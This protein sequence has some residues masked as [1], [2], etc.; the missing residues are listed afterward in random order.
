MRL[1]L[2]FRGG[3]YIIRN[4]H[5]VSP[6]G[7][8]GADFILSL[9]FLPISCVSLLLRIHR[10]SFRG[11]WTQ[12]PPIAALWVYMEWV[13]CH[14]CL[15]N[16]LQP[17]MNQRLS[18]PRGHTSCKHNCFRTACSSSVGVCKQPSQQIYAAPMNLQWSAICRGENYKAQI[19]V[20]QHEYKWAELPEKQQNAQWFSLIL[21]DYTVH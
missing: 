17:D 16:Q 2:S 20:F 13:G 21:E 3:A 9:L 5:I 19:L 18:F 14:W 10:K 11:Q 15:G 7:T 1:I 6:P 12:P 8:E 4:A